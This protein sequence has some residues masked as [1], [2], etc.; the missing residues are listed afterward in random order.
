MSEYT[1]ID[2]VNASFLPLI[3]ELAEAAS[4]AD[5]VCLFQILFSFDDEASLSQ[6]L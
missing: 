4:L 3:V 1:E 5:G 2:S 6:W